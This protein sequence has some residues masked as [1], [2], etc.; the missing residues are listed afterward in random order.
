MTKRPISESRVGAKR[1]RLD[2]IDLSS[3]DQ[4]SKAKPSFTSQ[5]VSSD[6]YRHRSDTRT[7]TNPAGNCVFYWMTRDHRLQDNYALLLAHDIALQRQVPLYIVFNIFPNYC[8][9]TYRQYDFMLTGLE[10]LEEKC[11]RQNLPMHVTIGADPAHNIQALLTRL[12]CQPCAIV[13]DFNPLRGP[14][15][16]VAGLAAWCSLQQISLFEVDAHNVIPC[17]VTSDKL[18]YSARTIRIKINRLVASYL[19]DF[20]KVCVGNA[21]DVF[22]A[23]SLQF[24]DNPWSDLRA[25]LRGDS[26]E[27]LKVVIA[28]GEDAAAATLQR[29]LE[30]KIQNYADKRNDPNEDVSESGVGFHL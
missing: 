6:R 19:V 14:Q 28:G 30:R 25:Q 13:T 16:W 23:S 5:L 27:D 4:A 29:F 10:E 26:T 15:S 1:S 21:E 9:T 24:A 20:P 17:W 2:D 7:I 3:D 8:Q 11:K 22:P 12:N 18:E